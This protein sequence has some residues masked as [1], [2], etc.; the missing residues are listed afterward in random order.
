MYRLGKMRQ[1]GQVFLRNKVDKVNSDAVSFSAD[2]DF[3]LFSR[4]ERF[5]EGLTADGADF[6]GLD[7]GNW[8]DE[9]SAR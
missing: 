1:V 9:C 3:E 6:R 7:T 4:L 8:I 5:E 2:E